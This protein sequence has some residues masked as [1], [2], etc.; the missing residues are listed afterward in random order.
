MR[1]HH[2]QQLGAWLAS[3]LCVVHVRAR[4]PAPANARR[5]RCLAPTLGAR[6]D[7]VLS[8]E[9]AEHLPRSME[10]VF[11]FNLDRHAK[12]GVVLSWARKGQGGSHHVNEQNGE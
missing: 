11:V 5:W 7:W 9:V 10:P 6:Y 8:L 1:I 12:E 3:A 2:W 4:A